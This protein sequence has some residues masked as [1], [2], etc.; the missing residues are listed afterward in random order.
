MLSMTLM[1]LVLEHSKPEAVSEVEVL[2]G[3]AR[4]CSR[5]ALRRRRRGPVGLKIVRG[6]GKSHLPPLSHLPLALW[7]QANLPKPKLLIL[8][9]FLH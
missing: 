1:C 2:G 4:G 6:S 8:L 3:K 7:K 5:A 9:F